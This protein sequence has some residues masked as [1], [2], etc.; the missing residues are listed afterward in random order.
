M[1]R[2]SENVVAVLV[3]MGCLDMALAVPQ[4]RAW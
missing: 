3:N 2:L 4:A 1:H